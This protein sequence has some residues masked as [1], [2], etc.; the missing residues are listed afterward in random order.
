MSL[1]FLYNNTS[2]STF[3]LFIENITVVGDSYW[4]E[5]ENELTDDITGVTITDTS[6]Y[7]ETYSTFEIIINDLSLDEGWYKY[8]LYDD[9]SK[10]LLLKFG[11]C[12]IY[13]EESNVENSPDDTSYEVDKNKYVYKK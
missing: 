9:S 6:L 13:D 4:L 3:N 8:T 7:P 12:Y 1:R 10:T 11:M 5:F 2:G